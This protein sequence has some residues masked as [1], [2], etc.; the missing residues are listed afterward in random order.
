MTDES[1]RSLGPNEEASHAIAAQPATNGKASNLLDLRKRNKSALVDRFDSQEGDTN[2]SNSG[3][4]ATS[5]VKYRYQKANWVVGSAENKAGVSRSRAE[6]RVRREIEIRAN[7]DDSFYPQ[8][9]DR[10]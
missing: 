10:N 1:Q 8:D 7:L 5:N 2:N 4:K 3:A 6:D 9:L